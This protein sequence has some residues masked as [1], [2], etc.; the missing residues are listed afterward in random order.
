M[1]NRLR[2]PAAARER[3]SGALPITGQNS[4][5]PLSRTRRKRTERAMR[6][7]I[8]SIIHWTGIV[9]LVVWSAYSAYSAFGPS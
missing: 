6:V 2:A 1:P 5:V 9:A 3:F 7:A 4:G 8:Y